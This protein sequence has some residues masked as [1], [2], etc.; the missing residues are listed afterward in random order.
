[1]IADQGGRMA[2]LSAE[3]EI[4]E[5]IAGRYSGNPNMNVFL[6]LAAIPGA[7]GRG[8]LARFLFSIPE[9]NIGMRDSN[10]APADPA[11]H[12]DY[13]FNLSSLI[14]SLREAKE[15]ICMGPTSDAARF[16]DAVAEDTEKAIAPGG[17]L[18]SLQDWGA[19]AVGAMMRIAALLHLAEHVRT[20][21]E[22]PITLDTVT[23]AHALIE[24]YTAHTLA[25]FDTMTTDPATERARHLLGWVA[26][27]GSTRFNA[28]EA[29]RG[30]P[31]SKFPKMIDLDP[32]LA[33]LG[34]HG[35]IRR[36]PAP[37]SLARGRPAAPEYEVH[38]A[39][40]A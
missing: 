1:M 17:P 28:R 38:P 12:T 24:Y 9:P 27:T 18:A 6:A 14:L 13:A 16:L 21:Y 33:L 32:A 19:K 7:V 30:L 10:P 40:L 11:A 4:F 23:A 35:H 20:G 25:A 39:L 15:P 8:L 31:R 3:S 22:R 29:F 37:P 36:L 5:V 2:I 26:R 34:Q